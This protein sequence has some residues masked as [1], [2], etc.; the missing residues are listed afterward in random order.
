MAQ[1]EKNGSR[2]RVS[3]AMT[4]ES[5]NALL[6]ESIAAFAAD[7][8]RAALAGSHLE[9]DLSGVTEADSAAIAL[10]F[11]WLR[12]AYSRKARV[13]FTNLPANLTSLATLY[14][15]LEL[16]PQQSSH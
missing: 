11:E 6:D 13:V 14:G 9:M 1:F 16:I 7:N 5:V 2:L 4:V 3:G 8:A 10:M 12:R 15:V